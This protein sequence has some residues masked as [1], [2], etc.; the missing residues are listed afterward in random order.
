MG[1]LLVSTIP[2]IKSMVDTP[3]LDCDLE[4]PPEP[5]VCKPEQACE[6]VKAVETCF[7]GIDT[8]TEICRYVN[9]LILFHSASFW[10]DKFWLCR[11][12]P[13]SF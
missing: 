13:I 3:W 6:P 1:S 11:Q 5:P 9:Q 12:C 7:D 10:T 8:F 4:L 2:T